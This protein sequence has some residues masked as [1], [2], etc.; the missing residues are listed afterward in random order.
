MKFSVDGRLY[1]PK[2]RK[3]SIAFS[4]LLL[5][6]FHVGLGDLN[7]K[8]LHLTRGPRLNILAALHQYIVPGS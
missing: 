6:I 5:F 4:V 3:N 2:Y 7:D 1:P 8:T